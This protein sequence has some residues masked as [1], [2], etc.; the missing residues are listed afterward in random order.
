MIRHRTCQDKASKHLV[1]LACLNEQ[2]GEQQLTERIKERIVRLSS[3]RMAILS[4]RFSWRIGISVAFGVGIATAVIVGALLV[5]DSMRG[6]LRDLTLQRLGKVESVLAPG[7]F[8]ETRGLITE[9]IDYAPLI[10]FQ[11]GVIEHRASGNS[12]RRSGKI[13]VIGCDHSFWMLDEYLGELIQEPNDDQ[14]ILN[15]SLADELGVVVGDFVNVRLP[16][17]QAVPADSPLGSR[18]SNTEGIPRLKIVQIIADRGLG[19]FSL[20]ASQATPLNVFLSRKVIAES[21][22]R[23]GQANMVL[24][25]QPV[26]LDSMNLSL[27]TLGMKL[28]KVSGQ[29]VNKEGEVEKVFEYNS[30]TS[31]SLLIPEAVAIR[32]LETRQGKDAVLQSTYL[33]NAIETVTT[34]GDVLKSIPYSTITAVD[35]S[36]GMPLD[37][38]MSAEQQ[39]AGLTP[40]VLNQW[41][42]SQ[43]DAT[44][45]SSVRIS[46]FEPEV[47][48]GREIERS[49]MAVVTSI[50]P[51]VEPTEPYRRRSQAVFRAPPTR[52]NDPALTPTVPGVTDQDSISDWD[53]PFKLTRKI[54]KSDDEYWNNHRLT[55]KLF[56]P[57]SAGRKYFGSRFGVVTSLRFP[58][59]DSETE[60]L[61]DRLLDALRPALPEIGWNVIPIRTDQLAAAGGTTPFDGLFLSLSFFVIASAILLIAMLFRLGLIQRMQQYGVLLITGWS[62]AALLRYIFYE[63]LVTAFIGVVI[64]SIFGV[65]YARVILHALGT[66]W[67]DAVTVPFLQFHWTFRSLFLGGFLG[68]FIAIFTLW[69]SARW[70]SKVPP[71]YLLSRKNPDDVTTQPSRVHSLSRLGLI[72][73]ALAVIAIG[74]GTLGAYS[75]GQIAAGAFVSSGMTLL[76]AALVTCYAALGNHRR[77][78]GKRSRA[79]FGSSVGLAVRNIS[80]YP[81][82]STITVGLISSAAF[83]IFAISA[84]QLRPTNEGT[85]G[86]HL[87]G[88]SSQPIYENLNDS[89]VRSSLMGADAANLDRT[90]IEMFRLKIGQDA[91]CNNLYRASRPT[92]LGVPSSFSSTLSLSSELGFRWAAGKEG[93]ISN[94]NWDALNREASGTL[95]DPIPVVL[96]Q[97]TAMWSLQLMKGIGELAEFEFTP[98]KPR[99]F[100]VVGLLSNSVLQGK[101][102]MSESNFEALFP[103]ISG[104]QFFMISGDHSRADHVEGVL[105]SRFS[106]IG[107]DLSNSTVLLERML[108]VQN[109]YLRTFQSLGAIGLLLGTVGLGIAQVRSVLERQ[110]EFAT[111]RS[112]GFSI[113]NLSLIVF[114]E[115]MLLLLLGVGLGLITATIAVL[116]HALIVGLEPPLLEPLYTSIAIV[117]FGLST[118]ILAVRK[119][120]NLPLL[121]S[122]RR[123]FS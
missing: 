120:S 54:S 87:I 91:S 106:D 112:V 45:G 18:E 48:N 74:L 98:G 82:R 101:L 105:E 90:F 5:G 100:K 17:E 79:N 67:V 113:K 9:D 85:G 57:L 44:V 121:D 35:S 53:L 116:P 119:V 46:Y 93:A 109:T 66:W 102:L 123:D 6:S 14:V 78:F 63:G 111:L 29:W 75:G 99:F 107:L 23:D 51:L 49:F 38:R 41:A 55:P 97:N 72:A 2:I 33:A 13:Q 84:F 7:S 89:A 86:F 94:K 56:L 104:Y 61:S 39:E 43:L 30:L 11:K 70:L 65:L 20:S 52:Y 40:V 12:V 117:A 15:Q 3:F 96:D 8:F 115:T 22:D 118:S 122:L 37:F 1:F 114:Q 50:V 25:D 36:P 59:N 69:F 10:F 62:P 16:V 68:L 27:E 88:E 73:F 60:V 42:A 92:V 95:D 76:F 58:M 110:S 32:I 83:L 26:S 80:R 28:S 19:R 108:A 47:E 24:F 77:F 4:F 64:G 103:G 21:L 31:E 34:N 71:H 81:S